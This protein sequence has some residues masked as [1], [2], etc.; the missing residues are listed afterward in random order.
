[1]DAKLRA[2][3]KGNLT[4]IKNSLTADFLANA[5]PQML[6]IKEEHA[7]K[8]F[9]QYTELLIKIDDDEDPSSTEETYYICL[10]RIRTA[11]NKMQRSKESHANLATGL[12]LPAISIPEFS[13]NYLEYKQF[14]E[15]FLA[16]VDSDTNIP[17]IQKLMYLRGFLKGEA[18]DLIK[19][20]PVQGASYAEALLLLKDRY[21]NSHQIVFEHISRILDMPSLGKSTVT[22]LRNFISEAKQH[23][24]ALKNLHEP[25]DRWDSILV[26]VL[27]RKLDSYTSRAYHLER[28][29]SNPPSFTDFIKFLQDRALAL[30]NSDN[31]RDNTSGHPPK[32]VQGGTRVASIA[33]KHVKEAI[34]FFCGKHDHKLFSCP[35]FLL[36]SVSERTDFVKSKHLCKLCLNSHAGK[37]RYYFKCAQCKRNHNTLLH[38]ETNTETT[39][40][41]ENVALVSG[42]TNEQVLLPT[43]QVKILTLD[44]KELTVRALLDSGSQ[45]SFI[46]SNLAHKIGKKLLPST[47]SIKG[48]GNYEHKINKSLELDIYSCA[49]PYKIK[50]NCL[51]VDEITPK[52][53]QNNFDVSNLTLPDNIVLAD[54]HYNISSEIDILLDAG[55]FFQTLLPLH[56]EEQQHKFSDPAQPRLVSTSFGYVL[57]G[58]I[59]VQSPSDA[60]VSLV[61]Q[62]CETDINS[63]IVKFWQSE[64]VPEIFTEHTSEQQYCEQYFLDTVK[65]L[66]SK[67]EVSMPLKIPIYDVNN[68]LG[69]S[70]GLALRRFLNLEKRLQKDSS[71]FDEYSKFIHEYI[72]LGHASYVDITEY[73]LSRD[74]VYFMP[75]HPVIRENAISTRLR[76]VFDG[77]MLTSNKISLNNILLNGPVVQNELFDVLLLFRL[78]KY[79]FTCDIRRMFRNIAIEKSQRSLQ[80]IL[81]RDNPSEPIKCLQLNTVTYGLKSSS[82]LATRCLNE[83]AFRY[84]NEYQLAYPVILNSTYVD[85]IL[86]SHNDL[87]TLKETKIQL[88][89]LLNKGSFTLHKWSANDAKILQDIPVEQQCFGEI[90]IQRDMKAL[91]LNFDIS[92]DSFVFAP[93]PRQSVKT[94]R[95]ILSFISTFYDPLGLIGPIFVKAKQ[96]MQSLWLSKTDW[97]SM[98]PEHIQKQWQEFYNELIEM[99]QIKIKRNVSLNDREKIQLIGFSDASNVAYGCSI[100]MRTVNKNNEVN[101]SLLCSKSRINP[102]NKTLSVPRLEL[103]AALL[104]AKLMNKV[105]KTIKET[106]CIDSTHLFTD[107][108]VVLAWL[109]TDPIKLNTYVANRVKMINDLTENFTWSY[110][111]TDEN[112]ADCLS[113][114]VNPSELRSRHLWW[115]GPH[116]MSQLE[117]NFTKYTYD[118]P[119]DL[120]ETKAP[121]KLNVVC[122]ASQNSNDSF[123]DIFINGFSNLGKAQRVLAYVLRFCHNLKSNSVKVQQNFIT[124]AE[125]NKALLLLVKHEQQKYFSEDISCLLK[126]KAVNSNLKGLNPFIDK[127]GLLRVGGRLQHAELSYA[128]KHQLILPKES[129]LTHLIIEYEHIK[130]LHASQKLILSNLNQRYWIVNGLRLIKHIIHK[131]MVCFRFRANTAKQLMGSLPADRVNASRPFQKVGMDFAG[132]ILVKQSRAR[133]VLTSKGYIIVYVCFTTKAIHLELVSDLTTDTFLASFKRF[134]SRRNVPSEVYCDNAAT[135]KSASKQLTELYN[136]QMSK[137]HQSQVQGTASQMGINFHFIPAYSPVFG[138]LWEA[139]VKSVKY[140]LKR[141]LGS[142]VFSYEQLY[143]VLTQIESV[144]N[145]RPLTPLSS[146][147]NDTSYLTPGHFL[148]G[149]TMNS[150]PERD[151]SKT[152]ENRLHFWSKCTAIKQSFWRQWAKHYLNILQNRPKWK[153]S[154]PNVKIGDLVILKEIEQAPMCWPMARVIQVFPGSDGKVR[155]MEVR[156]ANGRSHRTSITKI[157]LLPLD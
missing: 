98:P 116:N 46:T 123:F 114:G 80:N 66:D 157:C 117:Y 55:V 144:L 2:S 65:L 23:V 42:I 29:S 156:K 124:H 113:R 68:T 97:D 111:P 87:N 112:P 13:G 17:D 9:T 119:K 130:L 89:D 52:L 56:E 58:N 135:Y 48:I 128:Q 61:C 60:A 20:L 103:N 109:N 136:L 64:A 4:R 104:L 106:L 59:P 50:V 57:A 26:C 16:L 134:V 110:V 142:H 30:E 47:V 129:R 96:I 75:H 92:S 36:T 62:E 141:V 139:A 3:L 140:H 38:S 45:S 138:G 18:H 6:Q 121:T 120:P 105:Y 108:Q 32:K 49:Y 71:L 153:D 118:A 33:T 7:I 70:L 151:V 67:F 8:H 22:S 126:G 44:G 14:I 31:I 19:N 86:Y 63:N 51:V 73:D 53:P 85:D 69:D 24:A 82:Y 152:P 101:M 131:C 41:P 88:T 1:M 147:V 133:S 143:T 125:L 25:V 35:K 76:T 81:W 95:E 102:A 115:T 149:A 15:L 122:A 5:S 54:K 21:D 137:A 79:F 10:D 28:N 83:L 155:A 39:A 11:L 40:N 43:A 27:S 12:K 72:E 78:N 154:H 99:P 74:A 84:Q 100:Y 94:K 148:T 127:Q 93:P 77:S 107:S 150:I 37:C 145:S 90:N 34:C 146:D 91:G 132:P